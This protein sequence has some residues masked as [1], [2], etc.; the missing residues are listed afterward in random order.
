MRRFSKTVLYC[1]TSSTLLFALFC[2]L[3]LFADSQTSTAAGAGILGACIGSFA[4][5]VV[6]RLPRMMHDAWARER[7]GDGSPLADGAH[8]GTGP[9][10]DH[11]TNAPMSLT[12]PSSACPHCGAPIRCWHNVPLLGFLALRGRCADC[13]MPISRRYLYIEIIFTVTFAMLGWTVGPGLALVAYGFA[14]TVL[15]IVALIDWDHQLLPDCLTLSLLW[16]GLLVNAQGLRIGPADAVYGA[17]FGYLSFWLIA[18]T[19]ERITGDEGIGEG[20]GKLVAAL[21][22]WL[23]PL[24]L[25]WIM[26]GA[27]L[28]SLVCRAC[29]VAGSHTRWSDPQPFGPHLALAGCVLAWA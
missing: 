27:A 25:P 3:A 24:A 22:A 26:A 11:R 6:C 4:N 12:R 18:Q 19:Y 21:C 15:V 17:A 5:V 7:Q 9:P 23:G 1:V 13:A 2:G 14:F 10:N 29:L 8:H 28:S 20:D 16:A